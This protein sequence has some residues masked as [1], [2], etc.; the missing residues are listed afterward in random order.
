[1]VALAWLAKWST[2]LSDGEGVFKALDQRL[3]MLKRLLRLF[4]E[5]SF[6]LAKARLDLEGGLPLTLDGKVIG[7][8]GVSGATAQQDGQVAKAG[9]DALAKMAGH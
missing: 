9:A 4:H 3:H 8:I 7:A 6:N 2:L 5:Q 1:M